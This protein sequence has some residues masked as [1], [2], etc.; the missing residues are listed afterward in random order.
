MV[1]T[2]LFIKAKAMCG[3]VKQSSLSGL[4]CSGLHGFSRAQW[5]SDRVLDSRPM[6][7][8]FEPQRHHCVV[9]LSKTY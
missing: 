9:S 1:A 3:S 4:V 6:G 7:R 5:L 2:D 8:G